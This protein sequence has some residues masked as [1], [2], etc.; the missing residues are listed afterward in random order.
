[1]IL[2]GSR[3]H[4]Y[5]YGSRHAGGE[6][7]CTNG[8]SVARDLAEDVLLQKRLQEDLLAPEAIE[9]GVA[10]I[11]QAA[12]EPKC[13]PEPAEAARLSAE[14]GTL[15]QMVRTGQLSSEIATA[16]IERACRDR[17]ALLRAQERARSNGAGAPAVEAE[18]L[19]RKVMAYLREVLSNPKRIAEARAALQLYVGKVRCV[20]AE[21][22]DHLIADFGGER[23][24]L[25]KASSEDM[26]TL[27]AGAGFEPATFGL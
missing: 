13:M 20:P 3:P 9:L 12:S 1:M 4:R 22:H 5:V 7:A 8:L 10:T 14:I 15:E 27:V 19:Y 21:A 2:V 23:L 24:P 11:R 6:H 17:A 26:N 25:L 16:A 18:R